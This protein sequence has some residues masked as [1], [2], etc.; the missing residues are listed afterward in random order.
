MIPETSENRTIELYECEQFPYKWKFRRNLAEH[1]TAV[2]STILHHNNK[3]WVFTNIEEHPGAMS[4]DELFIFYTDDIINGTLQPHPLNPVVSDVRSARPA[5]RIFPVNGK[6]MR[7]SQICAPYY[8]WGTSI[9]EITELSE[10][11]Y[12]EKP[13]TTIKPDLTQRIAGVHTI[14]IAND[15]AVIDALFIR[16]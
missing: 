6:L 14:S 12:E 10:T 7:P 2:D 4:L 9:N 11:S 13:V 1:I 5:G 15:L 16:K 8:G 3:W